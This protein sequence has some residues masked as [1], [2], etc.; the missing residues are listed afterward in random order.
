MSPTNHDL[1]RQER[2]EAIGREIIADLAAAAARAEVHQEVF[3]TRE[4][5]T[6]RVTVLLREGWA[7]V[8]LHEHEH[9][10]VTY[11]PSVLR[12]HGYCRRCSR[13]A[14]LV[15][16]GLCRRCEDELEGEYRRELQEARP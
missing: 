9:S 6:A 14:A 7:A 1:D 4:E 2:E 16:D 3:A 13:G 8:A 15:R 12:P 5:A 10:V 11:R